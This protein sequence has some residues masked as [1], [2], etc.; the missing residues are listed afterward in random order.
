MENKKKEHKS[1]KNLFYSVGSIFILVLAAVAFIL[2]PALTQTYSNEGIIVGK[3]NGEPIKY[4]TDSYFGQMIEYYKNSLEQSGQTVDNNNFYSILNNAFSSTVLNMAINDEIESS[5]FVPP[6]NLINREMLPYFYDSE[7]KYSSKIFRDTPDS[8]KIEIKENIIKSVKYDTYIQDY[9]GESSGSIFGIRT[10]SKEIPFIAGINS[11]TRGFDFVSFS[12]D[13]YPKEKAAEYGIEN[14]DLFNV[15]DLSLITVNTENEATAL[16]KQITNNEIVFEDA[17]TSFSTKEYSS[18]DGICFNKYEYQ[19]KTILTNT[20]DL[21]SLKDL[22]PDAISPVIKTGESYSIFR[23]NSDILTPDFTKDTFIDVAYSY[24]FSKEMGRVE[25]HFTNIASDFALAALRDGFDV[26]SSQFNVEKTT[27]E[28][29]PLNYNNKDM[30][31]YVPSSS[32]PELNGGESNEN[33]LKTVFSLNQNEIS[34]PIILGSN[35]IVVQLTQKASEVTQVELDNFSYIYPYY[36]SEYDKS[37]LHDS[38]VRSDKVENN[39]LSV[40]FDHFYNYE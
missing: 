11:N 38:F 8:K 25:E 22:S 7:G 39:V 34:D 1:N 27:V 16:L 15:Y 33:F 2:V 35:V 4:E 10:S 37:S 19:I 14:P 36:E 31:V 21:T 28:P 29:F 18:E 24:I 40:Y 32:Y 23:K 5:G 6:D 13:T 20:D 12:T 3:W 26:A 17:I 9:F 30:L